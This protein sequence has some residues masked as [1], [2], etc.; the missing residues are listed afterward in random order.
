MKILIH[1]AHAGNFIKNWMIDSHGI[2]ESC[3][4]LHFYLDRKEWNGFICIFHADA[5]S[6][7]KTNNNRDD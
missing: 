4:S 1:H 6:L 5:L 3:C 2:W 7:H